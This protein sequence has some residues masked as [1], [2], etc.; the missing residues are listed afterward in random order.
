MNSACTKCFV[1][2]SVSEERKFLIEV[3]TKTRQDTKPPRHEG[4]LRKN[5][6]KNLRDTL[7]LRDFVSA[8]GFRLRLLALLHL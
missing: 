8:L 5:L 6:R 1:L 2:C 4:T 3:W 7:C